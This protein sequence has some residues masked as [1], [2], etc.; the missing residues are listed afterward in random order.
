M[1]QTKTHGGSARRRREQ[2]QRS[3]GKKISWMVGIVQA[4]KAHHTAGDK[5]GQVLKRLAELEGQVT[6]LQKLI[7]TMIEKATEPHLVTEDKISGSQPDD[8]SRT[9]DARRQD[10]KTAESAER[11]KEEDHE[12]QDVS[13]ESVG[14]SPVAGNKES[15]EEEPTSSNLFSLG[16]GKPLWEVVAEGGVDVHTAEDYESQILERRPRGTIFNGTTTGD[17][18]RIQ[19]GV[20]FIPY[21]CEKGL[22]MLV[23]PADLWSSLAKPTAEKPSAPAT[24]E[25]R[26]SGWPKTSLS[27]DDASRTRGAQWQGTSWGGSSRG[28]SVS[29]WRRSSSE[30]RSASKHGWG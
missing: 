18:I 25:G 28:W 17:W 1:E 23:C 2:S 9:R 3:L 11:R 19:N 27:T 4:T 12:V 7:N 29:T 5:E 16:A 22:R 21:F 8:A 15:K 13:M 26:M 20:G 10:I 14:C 24:S 6:F 30:W